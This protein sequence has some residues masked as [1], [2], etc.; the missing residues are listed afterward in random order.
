[1]SV[2]FSLADAPA[3][4]VC[5]PEDQASTTYFG[6]TRREYYAAHAPAEI[7]K[8]FTPSLDELGSKPEAKWI[9]DTEEGGEKIA[10]W[11]ERNDWEI[12]AEIERYFQ[13]R[14]YYASKMCRL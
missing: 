2:T 7:P 5:I 3:F 4:P 1:M 9:P 12:K 13:W 10:N 14:E 8:W 6:M 11:D